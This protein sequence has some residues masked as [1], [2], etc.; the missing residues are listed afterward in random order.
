MMFKDKS[1]R[2]MTRKMIYHNDNGWG[3]GK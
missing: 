2:N 3:L 1:P